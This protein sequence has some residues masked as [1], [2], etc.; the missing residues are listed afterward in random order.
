M[1]GHVRNLME[2]DEVDTAL[3]AMEQTH[4]G[5]GVSLRI[6]K[7][8]E[9]DILK[10]ETALMREV[11]VAKQFH[12]VLNRHASLCRH[13]LLTL[14]M[15]WRVKADGHMA[16]ALFEEALELVLESHTAHGDA[17][18]TPGVTIGSGKDLGGSQHIVEVVHRL[19]LPLSIGSPCPM[20]TI[21]V[22][23]SRSGRL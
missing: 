21:F 1:Q 10:R 12:D 3:K 6:V 14:L 7:S 4:D 8:A 16:L 17:L 13:Q 9:D 11:V 15:K 19:A 20:N 22:S 18:G 2:T 23:L 5:L